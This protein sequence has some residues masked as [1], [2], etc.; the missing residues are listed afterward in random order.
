M[1]SGTTIVVANKLDRIGVGIEIV[2]EYFKLAET[3]ISQE[4]FAAEPKV[5]YG[6][7]K[8]RRSKK[9]H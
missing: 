1:G 9:I 8:T 7:T 5:K 3:Q 6:K 2:Q 4:I